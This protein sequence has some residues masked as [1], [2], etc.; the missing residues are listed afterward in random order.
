MS[1]RAKCTCGWHDSW[2]S[3]SQATM[4]LHKHAMFAGPGH[5]VSMEGEDE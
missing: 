2:P 3:L 5:R 1:F 4:S